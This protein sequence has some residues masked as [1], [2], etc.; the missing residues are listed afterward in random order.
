MGAEQPSAGISR[1][2][3]FS[4]WLGIKT[5]ASP[6]P[7]ERVPPCR[8]QPSSSPPLHRRAEKETR[9]ASGSPRRGSA[10]PSPSSYH[11]PRPAWVAGGPLASPRPLSNCGHSTTV[12]PAS[13]SSNIQV[14][15]SRQTPLGACAIGNDQKIWRVPTPPPRGRAEGHRA[16]ADAEGPRRGRVASGALLWWRLSCRTRGNQL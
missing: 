1:A 13:P 5:P 9:C 11:R 12:V 15:T 3:R 6:A 16:R 2:R 10:L 8:R 4:R 14:R 7:V